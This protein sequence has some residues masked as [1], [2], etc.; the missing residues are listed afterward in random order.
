LYG[1]LD[2][3][4]K[5]RQ[6][7]LENEGRKSWLIFY[8]HDVRSKPSPYGCTPSLLESTAAFALQRGCRILTVREVLEELGVAA[9]SLHESQ[10]ATCGRTAGS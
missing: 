2:Q 7:I 6:L 5:T 4:E 9:Q 3:F 1:D 10:Y 8:S